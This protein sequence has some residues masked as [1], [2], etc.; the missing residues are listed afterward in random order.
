MSKCNCAIKTTHGLPYGCQMANREHQS[1]E[2]YIDEVQIFYRIM[3]FE[4]SVTDG[5][6]K[7]RPPLQQWQQSIIFSDL[8]YAYHLNEPSAT[9]PQDRL[10]NNPILR[11][12]AAWK[13]Q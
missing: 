9:H 4:K 13:M 10:K 8:S 3:S 11:E 5:V 2:F 6:K 1:D 7:D 12:R